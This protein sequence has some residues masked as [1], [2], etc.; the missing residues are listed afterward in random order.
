M[1]DVSFSY[2][3]AKSNA[4][5]SVSLAIGKNTTVG[6]VGSSGAGKST[7]VDIILGLLSPSS[8]NV[9]VDGMDIRHH[10]RAWQSKIGYIPQMIYLCDDTIKSNIGFG[11][12]EKEIDEAKVWEALRLAQLEEFVR[13][14]PLGINTVIGERGIR[15]SGGQ[16]QRISIARALYHDPEILVMD[17]ATA[18]LDNETERDFM[19]ALGGL[20]GGKTIIIIAH[21]LTTVQACDKIFFLKE[22]RLMA[23]GTYQE[24]LQN[25]PQFRDMAQ[26][27]RQ[28]VSLRG[29]L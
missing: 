12:D 25:C 19:E 6:M 7:T 23:Q 11:L 22:G 10:L 28:V 5:T 14:L 3:N 29:G 27:G 17:E 13:G 8:G 1:K 26:S 2:E 24:L 4:V 18:A 9:F 15:L 20:S 16:R 21:R